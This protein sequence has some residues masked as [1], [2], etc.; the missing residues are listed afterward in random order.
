MADLEGLSVSLTADT[1]GLDRGMRSAEQSVS[2]AERSVTGSLSRMDRAMEQVNRSTAAIAQRFGQFA[3]ILG[4][5]TLGAMTA[6][7]LDY[8]EAWTQIGNRLRLVASDAGQ[9]KET[10]DRLFTAAQKAGVGLSSVVDVYARASQAAG[11]LGASQEQLT[12]FSGG[13]AQALAVSGTSA[14]AAAGAMQQLGQLLGS[15]RVQAEEYNSV[16]DGAPRIAK[17]VADGLTEAGGSVSRLK[18]LINDGK[19]SNKQFFEAFLGQIPKI[20]AEFE[21]AVP[22]VGRSLATLNNAMTKMVGEANE[23][24]GA[25][26]ALARGIT[27]LADNLDTVAAYGGKAALALAAIA[28]VRMVPAGMA[29]LTRAIDDQKVALYAKAAATLEAA[30]AEQ[31]AAVQALIMTQRTQAA[32]AATVASAEAEFAARSAVAGTAA[33][34]LAAAE[35]SLLQAKAKT[36]LTTNVYVLNRALAAERDA[37][38]A[39]IMAREA[40]IAA[41]TAKAA[42][43]ARLR[44]A[45]LAAA[46]SGEAVA[47]AD[48]HLTAAATG[49]QAAS[50]ALAQRA[51]LLS[52]A[53]GGIRAAGTGL[54]AM[55]GGPWGAA[56]LAAGAAVYYLATRT[57]DADKAQ[58]AYNRTLAE[59][60][61]R[62]DELTGASHERANQLREEQRNE[63]SAAQAAADAA[64]KKVATLQ[65]LIAEQRASADPS[66]AGGTAGMFSTLFGSGDAGLR[67]LEAQLAAARKEVAATAAVLDGLMSIGQKTGDAVGLELASKLSRGTSAFMQLSTATGD[68]LKQAGLTI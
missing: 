60:R 42:S 36:S 16:L 44:N 13:V 7:A 40:S 41:D 33:S 22:T 37:E 58:E 52:A 50:A 24:T 6:K 32:A 3:A 18:Q 26:A 23:A 57:S 64:A 67:K 20:Q 29:G 54:L 4:V 28:T 19:V 47:A 51:S 59:G 1:G 63:L 53:W 8:A 45:Q 55:V 11:E 12:R 25:T 43:L 61:R 46:A 68:A 10:Q 56:F 65:A 39:V 2:R 49:A 66:E 35:A 27:A 21:T 14:E 15:A 38:A 48:A 34:N 9:L 30:K 62:I 5:G 17:A 31:L